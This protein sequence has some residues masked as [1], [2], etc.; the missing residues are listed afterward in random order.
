LHPLARRPARRGRL[1]RR[2]ERCGPEGSISEEVEI[3]VLRDVEE[4]PLLIGDPVDHVVAA[5][6]LSCKR[7]ILA[8]LS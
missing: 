1:R 4:Q 8:L 6:R 7:A 2:E 3:D 5:A